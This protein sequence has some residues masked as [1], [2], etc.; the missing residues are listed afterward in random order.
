MENTER[1][2][3]M[4]N[5]IRSITGF[6]PEVGIVLGSLYGKRVIAMQGRIH[7]YEGYG[8]EL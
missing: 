8:A 1:V 2:N 5:Y 6:N 3:A 4:I 7:Y